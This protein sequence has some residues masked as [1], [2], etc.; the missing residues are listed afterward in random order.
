LSCR[1]VSRTGISRVLSP[2]VK[3]SD[4]PVLDKTSICGLPDAWLSTAIQEPSGPQN[5]LDIYRV[6]AKML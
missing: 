5:V 4:T 6:I 2:Q 3:G 1:N